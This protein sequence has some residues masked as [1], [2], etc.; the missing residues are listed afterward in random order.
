MASIGPE[1]N[2]K[3]SDKYRYFMWRPRR[4]D[5]RAVDGVFGISKNSTVGSTIDRVNLE[6]SM[7]RGIKL[8]VEN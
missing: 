6:M 2:I 3:M 5:V 1:E 7:G 8:R 4:W